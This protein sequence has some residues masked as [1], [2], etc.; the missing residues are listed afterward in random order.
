MRIFP[1]VLH[2]VCCSDVRWSWIWLL[3]HFGDVLLHVSSFCSENFYLAEPYRQ[4]RRLHQV[5][6]RASGCQ[7][8]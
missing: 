2:T 7:V 1:G 6:S 3:D 4:E 8:W 5:P